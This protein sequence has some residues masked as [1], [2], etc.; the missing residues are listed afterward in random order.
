MIQAQEI[1][2]KDQKELIVHE[3]VN[4]LVY[5]HVQEELEDFC[6]FGDMYWMFEDQFD[7]QIKENSWERVEQE[8]EDT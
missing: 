7:T 1:Y 5:Y 8:K 4:G 2:R 3:R 6:H